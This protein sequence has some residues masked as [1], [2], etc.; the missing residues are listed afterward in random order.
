MKILVKQ[1][2]GENACGGEWR[3]R[4]F[5]VTDGDA[6]RVPKKMQ[7]KFCKE[8][9]FSAKF[10]KEYNFLAKVFLLKNIRF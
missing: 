1:P 8:Y 2:N 6:V 4:T 7:L 5:V 10:C 3:A 9:N